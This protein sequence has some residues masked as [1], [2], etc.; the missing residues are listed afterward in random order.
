MTE[1][2]ESKFICYALRPTPNALR[3]NARCVTCYTL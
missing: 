1:G 3:V 2:G